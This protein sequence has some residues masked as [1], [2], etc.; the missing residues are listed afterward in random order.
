MAN[1]VIGVLSRALASPRGRT[2][3][4]KGG[5]QNTSEWRITGLMPDGFPRFL[6]HCEKGRFLRC[7]ISLESKNVG[8]GK[9]LQL[10]TKSKLIGDGTV[11]EAAGWRE[12]PGDRLVLSRALWPAVMTNFGFD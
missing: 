8:T 2:R 6:V 4:I 1:D 5:Y 11:N 7:K 10:E 9:C 12:P 3:I